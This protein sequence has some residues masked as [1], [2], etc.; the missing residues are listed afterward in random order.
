M[1]FTEK[2]KERLENAASKEEK[3]KLLEQTRKDVEEAG[4]I[5]DEAELEEVVGGA[6]LSKCSHSRTIN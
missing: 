5:L 6:A 2:L 3:S 1:K 4:I